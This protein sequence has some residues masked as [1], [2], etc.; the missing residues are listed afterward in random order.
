MTGRLG[1]V[2]RARMARSGV[3]ALSSERALG[4]LDASLAHGGP[5]LLAM[6]LDPRAL[7]AQSA[8]GGPPALLRALAGEGSTRRTAASAPSPADWGP[9]LAALSRDQQ[10]RVLLD[11]V[12]GHAAAVL[13]HSAAEA[14]QAEAPFKEMGFD[15]LTAVE[16]RNRLSAASGLRLPATFVFRY[17]SAA[18][19]AEYLREN[20]CP[21]GADPAQPLFA[22]V[23]KLESALAR[24]APEGEVRSRLA[25]RLE[26]LAWRL[27]DSAAEPEQAVDSDALESA[28]DDELFDLIDREVPS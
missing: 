28:S 20:L 16:L 13:G 5:H 22:E 6:D 3:G 9:R 14:I 15:S 10:H 8:T 21:A 19:V 25:K 24:F 17:P 1:V 18:A 7:T 11:L 27:G 4:L 12:R 26:T 23:E 2:D